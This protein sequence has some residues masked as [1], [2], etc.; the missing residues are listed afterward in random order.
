[1]VAISAGGLISSEGATDRIKADYILKGF[2]S[3]S[4]DA[5][6]VQWRD[7]AY[8]DN[9]SL[10][11]PLPWVSSNW[12]A[13]DLPSQRSIKREI[14]GQKVTLK[15][16]SWLEPQQSPMREMQGGEV[17]AVDN[18]TEINAMVRQADEGGAVTVL[19]TTLPLKDAQKRF[20][21]KHVDL[22][23]IEAAYEVFSE[24]K[25]VGKTLV[26]QAGSRGMRIA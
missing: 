22:L 9:F 26:L 24:P 17:L 14:Q 13:K 18:A 23:F 8:G 7:L 1:M 10:S 11:R 21:L 16:F 3:L 6:G 25:K 5:I 20:E 19:I 15:V 12:H 2:S 4:Y